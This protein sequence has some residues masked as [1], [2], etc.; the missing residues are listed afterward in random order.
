M[1]KNSEHKLTIT[2][3]QKTYGISASCS[4]GNWSKFL[5]TIRL[6]GGIT[7]SKDFIRSEFKSHKAGN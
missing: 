4:C 5:N 3:G 7:S 2:G 6:R 1:T